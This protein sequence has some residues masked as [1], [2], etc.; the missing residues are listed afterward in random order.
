MRK[1]SEEAW[2]HGGCEGQDEEILLHKMNILYFYADQWLV[3]EDWV[4]MIMI[5]YKMRKFIVCGL[6]D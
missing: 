3:T 4:M 6:K 2:G 5:Q 1:E